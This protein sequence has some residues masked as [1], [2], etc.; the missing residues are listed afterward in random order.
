MNEK[1]VIVADHAAEGLNALVQKRK[2]ELEGV[3]EEFKALEKELV[4]MEPSYKTL[5]WGDTKMRCF[6]G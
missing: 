5:E 2:A 6:F 1:V 4:K 3:K